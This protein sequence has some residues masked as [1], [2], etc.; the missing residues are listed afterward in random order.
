MNITHTDTLEHELFYDTRLSIPIDEVIK[1]LQAYKAI[2]AYAPSAINK[3][4]DVHIQSLD[5]YVD[6]IE[7]GSLIE[8]YLVKLSFGTEEELDEWLKKNPNMRKVILALVVTGL[9]GTGLYLAYNWHSNKNT[10]SVQ[11]TGNNNIV[12]LATSTATGKSEKEVDEAIKSAVRTAQKTLAENSVKLIQPLH[13]D[14]HGKLLLHGNLKDYPDL[15]EEVAKAKIPTQV[16]AEAPKQYEP[17]KMIQRRTYES[18][19]IE[20][21]ATDMDKSASGWAGIAKGLTPARLQIEFT[22]NINAKALFGYKSILANVEVEFRLNAKNG[23]SK[24][25]KILVFEVLEKQ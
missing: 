2:L 11:I 21:R 9:V 17:P 7:T 18:I 15:K 25:Y 6:N 4:L 14:P 5:I 13:A 12:I 20:L 23:E 8:K 19:W 24:P 22:E 3:L 16:I 10:N 1:S